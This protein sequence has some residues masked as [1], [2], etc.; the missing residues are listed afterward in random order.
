MP[1]SLNGTGVTFNDSTTLQSGNI[2]AA[3]MGSGTANSSVFLRGDKTWATVPAAAPSTTDVL[4]A[5]AGASVGAV[6]TYAWLGHSITNSATSI[7][8]TRAGSQLRYA[9]MKV[10]GSWTSGGSLNPVAVGS[11]T[12]PAGT[13]RL[14][15]A[16]GDNTDSVGN[17]NSASG[18]SLWLRIS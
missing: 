3:N 12:A 18:A 13:W 16:T 9:G 5:T 6:G 14:L 7:G 15:G 4:N 10:N 1:S 11:G 2:P 8:G 17:P